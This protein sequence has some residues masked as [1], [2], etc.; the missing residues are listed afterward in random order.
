MLEEVINRAPLFKLWTGPSKPFQI[1]TA[2]EKKILVW[3]EKHPA[4]HELVSSASNTTE[5]KVGLPTVKIVES[6]NEVDTLRVLAIPM[7]RSRRA[8][9]IYR[10][11]RISINGDGI[12]KKVYIVPV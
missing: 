11:H 8:A 5:A 9:I 1:P 3:K 7:R 12:I 6:N 10:R 2:F 4:E